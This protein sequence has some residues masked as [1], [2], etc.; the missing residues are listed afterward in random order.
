MVAQGNQLSMA[1]GESGLHLHLPLF[2]RRC[3]ED[4]LWHGLPLSLPAVTL[5]VVVHGNELN[6]GEPPA[7]LVLSRHISP[8]GVLQRTP[9]QEAQLRLRWAKLVANHFG[10]DLATAVEAANGGQ[11][12]RSRKRRSSSSISLTGLL[13]RQSSSLSEGSQLEQGFQVCMCVCVSCA[14]CAHGV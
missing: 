10:V 6:Q 3:H 1:E 7:R 5:Q 14:L 2:S 12:P 8:E 13:R 4:H 9:E 11:G